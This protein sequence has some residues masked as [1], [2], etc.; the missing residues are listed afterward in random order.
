MGQIGELCEEFIAA[1]Y[2]GE[3]PGIEVD[4]G[5]SERGQARINNLPIVDQR[6]AYTELVAAFYAWMQREPRFLVMTTKRQAEE[7]PRCQECTKFYERLDMNLPRGLRPVLT[8]DDEILDALVHPKLRVESEQDEIM[9]TNNVSVLKSM[10]MFA[11]AF[12][13]IARLLEMVDRGWANMSMN[14]GRVS[15]SPTDQGRYCSTVQEAFRP[16]LRPD[17]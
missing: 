5:L 3:M 2:A 7:N 12:I 8:T 16:N 1:L 17:S 6:T 9:A 10:D 15:F 11:C 13:P 14:F 4:L